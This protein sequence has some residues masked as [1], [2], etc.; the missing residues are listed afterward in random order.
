MRT[1]IRSARLEDLDFL[2]W[3]EEQ[4]FPPH[5]RCSRNSLRTS[6]I[7][8]K[9]CTYIIG[10]ILADETTIPIGAA[11]VIAYKQ[12]QRI[13][14]LA[15]HPDFRG[16]GAGA[17]LVQHI[18]H[19]ASLAGFEK[20]S[21][22]ADANNHKL[23]CWYQKQNF[24][25][26]KVLGDYYAPGEPAYRMVHSLHLTDTSAPAPE[27][28]IVVD[29]LK[30]WTLH[31]ENVEVVSAETYLTSSRFKNAKRLQVLNLCNSYKTHS[32][33]Y[34][35]SLLAAA[36]NQ[37]I[38]PT[39][40]TVKDSCNI[41]IAQSVFDEIGTRPKIT[42]QEGESTQITV[43]LGNSPE[44]AHEEIARKLFRLFEIPFF[45]LTLKKIQGELL[46]K[47]VCVLSPTKV[48][49]EH[50][51]LLEQSLISH[52][53]RK[54][55]YRQQ[56]KK[57]KYDLAILT[58]SNE[59]TP[60]SCLVAL[61][62]FKAAAE[63]VGFFVEFVSKLDYRRI[64][65]FDALFIR[66]TTAIENH[67]YR[68]ARHAYTE[69][70]TVLDDPWSILLCSN[71]IYLHERLNRARIRQPKSWL[72]TKNSITKELVSLFSFPLVLKLPEST[73]SLGVY[74]VES[75]E[76]FHEK[77]ESLFKQSDL[78]IAQEFLESEFDWRIG[79]LD[80]T[81]LFACKYYMARGH[82]QIYNWEQSNPEDF[83]GN[84]ESIPI[85]QV[86][87]EILKTAVKASSLIGDSLY[88]VDLKEVGGK[89]YVIEVND[90]PNI[91]AG[92]EDSILGDEL[93]LRIM[94]SIFNR[95]ERERVQ[96]RYLQ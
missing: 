85:N 15:I 40:M 27:N 53:Q 19:A 58:D 72:L 43:I 20:V 41:G 44:K 55:H 2:V 93:Y 48:F 8:P 64:C 56:L 63:K 73:F 38:T 71:K 81:P 92:I 78:V 28:I 1:N 22:E 16:S 10:Q 33:G 39:V 65:E 60:P 9:H 61:E 37:R 89:P 95:L 87:A 13:Y 57:H 25:L 24:E 84:F 75:V 90:N 47:K 83:S 21:I 91:D 18:L 36:R 17:G 23:I 68:F 59:K 6:I 30:K 88:G 4:S 76:A 29:Q 52:F 3:L 49:A 7:S 34:Y 32:T 46:V 70:L 42:L 51:D 67:T 74:K 45:S 66:E 79:I 31:L 82:W 94:T 26:N 5:R 12:S 69:G 96:P 77:L 54:R 50:R 14:S 11:V 35:V 62:K 86:P 80:N